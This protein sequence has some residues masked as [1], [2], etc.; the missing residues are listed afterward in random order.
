MLAM[1]LSKKSFNATGKDNSRRHPL[2]QINEF[3]SESKE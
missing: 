1:G 3:D 2:I